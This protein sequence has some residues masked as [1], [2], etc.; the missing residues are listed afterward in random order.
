MPIYDRACRACGW[1]R[2]DCF[3]HASQT[4]L[5]CPTC[6]APTVRVFTTRVTVIPDSYIGGLTLENLG[7]EPVTVHSRSE[8][9]REMQARGLEP[10][11][12]H[13]GEPGSDKSKHTTN[14]SAVGA[15]ALTPRGTD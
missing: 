6:G 13:V 7:H 4:E 2:D 14:W 10:F 5:A 3:E 8:L 15:D 12:R 9:K 11:V 1:E